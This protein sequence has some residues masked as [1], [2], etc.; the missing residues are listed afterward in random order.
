MPRRNLRR[1]FRRSEDIAHA[2][3]PQQP[4]D[5]IIACVVACTL[6]P[7]NDWPLPSAIQSTSPHYLRAP[8]DLVLTGL[9]PSNYDLCIS[10][11]NP[12]LGR[13]KSSFHTHIC[14]CLHRDPSPW[15]GSRAR[16]RAFQCVVL[17]DNSISVCSEALEHW[18]STHPTISSRSF[19]PSALRVLCP[20]A[21]AFLAR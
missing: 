13:S 20:L 3:Y 21:A 12:H 19:D 4:V 1:G 9:Q 14:P 2:E 11:P 10:S 6:P 8:G 5:M 7:S 15:S 16:V 17:H 18:Y